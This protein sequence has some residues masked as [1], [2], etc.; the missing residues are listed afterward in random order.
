MPAN[1]AMYDVN[2]QSTV[3][4]YADKI[5][6]YNWENGL[7]VNLDHGEVYLHKDQNGK[8]TQIENISLE[9]KDIGFL[10]ENSFI[11]SE[12]RDISF[13]QK[14]LNDYLESQSSEAHIILFPAGNKC[15]FRCK[16]CYENHDDPTAY[17]D[18]DTDLI[19][20]FISRFSDK[21]LSLDFFGGEPLLKA[22][23]ILDLLSR[24]DRKIP[25]SITTNGYLLD[26]NL[27]LSLIDHG[28][29]HYQITL[30][31]LPDEHNRLRPLFN[32]KETW[33]RIY[34]NIHNTRQ[35]ERDFKMIIRVNFNEKSLNLKKLDEF[36]DLFRFARYDPRYKFCFRA[37][38]LYSEINHTTNNDCL[39]NA[40]SP[41]TKMEL[42]S[43][44]N[45]YAQQKGY[46]LSDASIFSKRGGMV[47]YASK[48]N[49]YVINAKK[50]ILKCTVGLDRQI[51]KLSVL[52]K[53]NIDNF[54]IE[55]AS[56]DWNDKLNHIETKCCG[57]SMFF[58]CFARNCAFKNIINGQ[59][60][61]PYYYISREKEIVSLILKN[62]EISR[63]VEP[64][65]I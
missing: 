8:L 15:N 5:V 9:D 33:Q 45:A 62:N 17:T 57:C 39:Q 6:W 23:W 56:K 54:T 2:P 58:Q 61:C 44:F 21:T 31:G 41:S 29:S 47:C 49:T 46:L 55:K 30:D 11:L 26:R 32:G 16:Y 28:L 25:S 60:A 3:L 51:N 20:Y 42:L 65:D 13:Y 50:E 24:T 36:L 38:E 53:D 34:E 4:E 27:F 52:T 1:H 19:S 37:I 18:E 22:K 48:L 63:R 10:K 43:A 12:K 40:C 14:A 7:N 35:V 64:A 59:V